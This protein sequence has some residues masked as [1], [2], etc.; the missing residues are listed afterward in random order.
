MKRFKALADIEALATEGG[1]TILT[2]GTGGQDALDI[3]GAIFTSALTEAI[4]GKADSD[5]NGVLDYYELF[6]YVWDRASSESG[7]WSRK[8]QLADAH[9]G[10]GRWVFVYQ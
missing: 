5:R 10:N 6:A 9:L 3:S 7:Q 2:A 1:R 4:R 8:Q